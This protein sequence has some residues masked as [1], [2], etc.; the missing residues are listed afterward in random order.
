LSKESN[1][2]K[3]RNTWKP[4]IAKTLGKTALFGSGLLNGVQEVAGSNPVAPTLQ[5]SL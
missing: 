5:A 4:L 1:P 2:R 3:I